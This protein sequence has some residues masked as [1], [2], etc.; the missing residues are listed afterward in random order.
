MYNDASQE[1]TLRA[2]IRRGEDIF[3][4]YRTIHHLV[5]STITFNNVRTRGTRLSCFSNLYAS[6]YRNKKG[7]TFQ[8]EELY[9]AGTCGNTCL[10]NTI[11]FLERAYMHR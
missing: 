9:T 5:T 11:S 8:C 7:H 4:L 2:H 6:F 3:F 10:K 1:Q